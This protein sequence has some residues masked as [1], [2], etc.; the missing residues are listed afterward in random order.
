MLDNIKATI[1]DIDGTLLDSNDVWHQID[2]DFMAERNLKHTDNLQDEVGGLSFY[3][4]AC[5]FKGKFNLQ[6]S[7]EELLNIWHGMAYKAY[8]N[9]IVMKKGAK[10][11]LEYLHSIDMPIA[12]CTSNSHELV[13]A[14]LSNNGVLDIIDL[15]VTADDIG[16][17]KEKPDIYLEIARRLKVDPEDC[18]AFDDINPAL[19]AINMA[20]MTSCAVYDKYSVKAY[21]EKLLRDTADYFIYD[22]RDI[23][24]ERD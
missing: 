13:E 10:E 6:E 18:L 5:Y 17:S 3:Q 14:A 7:A 1:F 8:S 4:V 20:N 2:I 12:I 15:I 23:E 11:Y 19:N 16:T 22:F 9:D 21:S 24:Y